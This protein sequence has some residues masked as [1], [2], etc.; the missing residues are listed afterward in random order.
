M[1]RFLFISIIIGGLLAISA[2]NVRASGNVGDAGGGGPPKQQWG[3]IFT[4]VNKKEWSQWVKCKCGPRP[5]D[6][7]GTIFVV[8][9]NA[10]EANEAFWRE[11]LSGTNAMGAAY[12]V[13]SGPSCSPM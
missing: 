8:A 13:Q 10:A 3:C 4:Y 12:R 7:N 1:S 5:P 6:K 11:W 9:S 2:A